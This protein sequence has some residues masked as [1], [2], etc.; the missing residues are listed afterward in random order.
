MEKKESTNNGE[1][2]ELRQRH[3]YIDFWIVN[4]WDRKVSDRLRIADIAH[5]ANRRLRHL[6][7][8]RISHPRFNALF[9]GRFSFS[10]RCCSSHQAFHII[11]KWQIKLDPNPIVID[12]SD[13]KPAEQAKNAITSWN[14]NQNP[15]QPQAAFVKRGHED[16]TCDCFDFLW[17]DYSLYVA[18]VCVYRCCIVATFPG[19]PQYTQCASAFRFFLFCSLLSYRRLTQLRCG[20][21]FS[22]SRS[23]CCSL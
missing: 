7:S 5:C 15:V 2:N 19:W 1:S 16:L 8:T 13:Q 18:S 3:L 21:N 6:S 22:C 11:L 12:E 20:H 9:C 14:Y 10:F 4:R 17:F 23:L